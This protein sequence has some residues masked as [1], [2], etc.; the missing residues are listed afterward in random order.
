MNTPATL[1]DSQVTFC[2][3]ADLQASAHFYEQL[4]GLPLA[5]DQGDCRIYKTS[6]TAY[7]AICRRETAPRPDGIILTLVS[8]DVDGW[9]ARLSAL[10]VEFEKPPTLNT[11]F[12]I[13][14]C[15]FRD[16]SGYLLEI[17]RFNDPA[18]GQ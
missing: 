10:G 18:W 9:H 12:N 4:L 1:F 17:Q 13:Y 11:Q 7:L 14:H 3:S 16:P 15:F 2:Y 5:L 6:T 8:Q